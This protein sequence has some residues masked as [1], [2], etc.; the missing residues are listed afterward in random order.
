MSGAFM[1]GTITDGVNPL[2]AQSLADTPADNITPSRV[3]A[4]AR[5]TGSAGRWWLEYG[6]RAQGRVDRVAE[7]VLDSPF[8]IPQ[9]LLSLDRFVVQRV[10]AGITLTR[11]AQRVGLTLAVENLGNV[12]YREHFQFAPA[13]GRTFTVGLNLGAF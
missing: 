10:G 8:L 7:T 13:R 5:Y 6:V 2:N 3:L 11:G 12:Y 4:S 1:R 9:D